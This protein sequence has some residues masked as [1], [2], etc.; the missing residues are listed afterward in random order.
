MKSDPLLDQIAKLGNEHEARVL[1][2]Y[3]SEFGPAR[4]GGG[5]EVMGRAES[6]TVEGLSVA[7][8]LTRAAFDRSPDLV[9]QAAFFDGEFHGYADFIRRTPNGWVVADT[10]IARTAKTSALLQVAAYADQ[11]EAWG[12]PLASHAE[13]ILGTGEI[14]EFPLADIAPVFR[15]R[16]SRLRELI[17]DHVASGESALWDQPGIGACGSCGDCGRAAAASDDL[18]L[19]AGMRMSQ[20]RKLKDA[21]SP[22]HTIPELVLALAAPEGFNARTFTKLKAQAALQWKQIESERAGTLEITYEVFDAKPLQALP[23]PSDGDLFFDFEGDPM[24][25]AGNDG[26][27]GLE[28]LWGVLRAR[29]ADGSRGDFWPLW[30]DDREQERAALVEFLD[31]VAAVRAAHPDMHIYHYAPYEITALKRLVAEHKTHEAELDDLLRHGVFVDLY[32]V[33]R[34]SVRVSQPS[35]SIKK[36]EPLYMGEEGREGDVTQGDASIAQYHLYRELSSGPNTDAEEADKLKAS[37]LDYNAYDCVSTLELRDWLL[38]RV[39]GTP[40]SQSADTKADE[41]VEEQTPRGEDLELVR[42]RAAL[43][44]RSGSVARAERTDDEQAWAMLEGA[45]GYYQREDRPYWWAHF[46]RLLTPPDEWADTKDVLQFTRATAEPWTEKVGNRLPRRTVSIIGTPGPGSTLEAPGTVT[47]LYDLPAPDGVAVPVHGLRGAAAR[48]DLVELE[49]L[50]DG[51]VRAVVVEKLKRGQEPYDHLPMAAS[52][53]A[54]PPTASIVA[55]IRSVAEQCEAAGELTATPALD[56]LARR[57]PRLRTLPALPHSESDSRQQDLV[58]AL[59][60]LDHS[61]LAVQGPPGTGKTYLGSRVIR[62][63]VENHGWKVGVVGQ[64]H[65][66]VENLLCAVVKAGLNEDLVGKRDKRT[67]GPNS[68]WVGLGSNTDLTDFCEDRPGGYVIGGTAWTFT[69]SGVPP[70]SLDLLVIDEAGQFA[71]AATVGASV[72]AQ[73]LLLLGDPQQLPQVSQGCHG[74]PVD[75]SALSWVIGNSATMPAR[76]GYFLETSYRMHP[77]VCSV[78]SQLSYDGALVSA[79][80]ASMRSLDGVAPGLE[81]VRLDHRDNSVSS[82]EEA[83]VVVEQVERLMGAIWNDP[84]ESPQPRPLTEADFLVVAP[85][86]AQRKL[87]SECLCRAGLGAVK[88]G[89]VDKFQGQ[90]APVVIVS[91]TASSSGEVPRGMEFLLNRNRVNVAVSRAQWLAV[92]I[93][94]EALTAHMPATPERLMELGGFIGLCERH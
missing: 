47:L 78:V 73:R 85:Y 76:L 69:G 60:D 42:L 36:L 4:P 35:Y 25:S 48:A 7:A 37:L 26:R 27:W 16:R 15:E 2:D 65:A 53:S 31:E 34:A 33:V 62:D 90:E 5:V 57:P 23:T 87:I 58:A 14:Q 51:T 3:L 55:A 52:P 10:K 38:G 74:E 84:S 8:G 77:K 86:N 89:T 82:R 67:D 61:Y 68:G 11:L 59:R 91:M 41:E 94:S 88:V 92:L 66:V 21:E 70:D 13:L 81:V 17:K 72:A 40:A 79:P 43:L 71:L 45:L 75:Q 29:R 24:F 46:D 44:D 12:L 30:A 22:I 49:Q 80:S 20:R 32:A 50:D 1:A 56:I 6:S 18:I 93:R 54:P 83:D 9:V 39:E 19:I 63:L 64:S 28:Y